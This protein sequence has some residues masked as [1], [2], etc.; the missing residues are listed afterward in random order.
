MELIGVHFPSDAAFERE[1][2]I[3]EKT[4]YDWRRSKSKSYRSRLPEIAKM[5]NT[6]SSYLLGED[7]N[8]ILRIPPNLEAYETEERIPV[9]KYGSIRAG[10]GSVATEDFQGYEFFD[11]SSLNGHL[12]EDYFCTKITGD[13]M[14][15]LL[16]EGDIVLVRQQ[17]DVESGQVA[18]VV[19]GEDEATVKKIKKGRDYIELIPSNPAHESQIVENGQLDRLRIVGLVV[20]MKRKF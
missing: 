3:P 19:V 5:L 1:L 18:V 12:A 20:E 9:P 7:D 17:E 11:R 8:P 15:P 14:A 6:S 10:F 4:V 13:S 16:I 2:G